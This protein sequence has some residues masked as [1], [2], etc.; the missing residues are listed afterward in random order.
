[1]SEMLGNYFFLSHS[2]DRAVPALE[3][4]LAAE[5]YQPKAQKKLVI[6]YIETGR[7]RDGYRLYCRI[8]NDDPRII[9]NTDPEAE[10]CPCPHFVDEIVSGSRHF[11]DPANRL[12]VL[13]IYSSYCCAAAAKSYL[14]SYMQLAPEDTQAAQ[15]L[16]Q[17]S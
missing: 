1:M 2:F 14:E 17:L 15:I 11:D 3:Q 6:A 5:P 16:K 4:I 10:D 8:M 13:A 9:L 12:L 7:L